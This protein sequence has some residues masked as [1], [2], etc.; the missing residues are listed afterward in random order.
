MMTDPIADMLTRIRNAN[1]IQRRELEMP[2][3]RLK[4]GVAEALKS[5]GFIESYEVIEG[6]PSS[7]LRITLKY[8]P[9]G[10]R[11]IR[12]IDRVSKPGLR[13]YSGAQ[14]LPR[15]VRGMGIH[16]LSTPKGVLSDRVARRENVGG[17]I[18]CRVY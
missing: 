2:A 14:K 6:T 9:D 5:E 11:V 7:S 17:E 8:G 18:L 15:V 12:A 10:E 16:I 4:V 13:R 3:S 1:A